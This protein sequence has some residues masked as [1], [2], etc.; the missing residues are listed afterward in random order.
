VKKVINQNLQKDLIVVGS[1][2]QISTFDI[3]QYTL[4]AMGKNFTDNRHSRIEPKTTDPRNICLDGAMTNISQN[5]RTAIEESVHKI[6][7]QFMRTEP[8]ARLH[9]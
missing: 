1:N 5:F 3:L 8:D 4:L 2:V 7:L 6:V 9:H